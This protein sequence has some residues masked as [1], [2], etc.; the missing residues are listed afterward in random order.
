MAPGV[1]GDRGRERD[2]LTSP[3]PQRVQETRLR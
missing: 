2:F 1:V 3:A